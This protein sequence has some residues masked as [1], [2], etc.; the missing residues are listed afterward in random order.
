MAGEAPR[1]RAVGTH[2]HP[3]TGRPGKIS[4]NGAGRAPV[5]LLHRTQ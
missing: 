3:L 2:T 1:V 5:R 4:G